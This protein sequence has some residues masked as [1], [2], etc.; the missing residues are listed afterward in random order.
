MASR[1]YTLYNRVYNTINGNRLI[2]NIFHL[3]NRNLSNRQVAF[4]ALY[5][6]TSV[7]WFLHFNS[8]NYLQNKLDFKQGKK[9]QAIVNYTARALIS[10][11]VSVMMPLSLPF[12]LGVK[13]LE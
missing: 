5:G 10:I 12:V 2:R 7:G 1:S 8:T 9:S 4:V 3:E 11:P 13:I 6:V